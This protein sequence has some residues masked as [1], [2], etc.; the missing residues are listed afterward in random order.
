MI[1]ADN[2]DR[3]PLGTIAERASRALTVPGA[4]TW[5][6]TRLKS[7]ALLAQAAC[8][9]EEHEWFGPTRCQTHY[10][11]VMPAQFWEAEWTHD[12]DRTSDR[13]TRL[14][15]IQR[16]TLS[17]DW[18]GSSFAIISTHGAPAR[19]FSGF[20]RAIG[21]SLHRDDAAA[22]LAHMDL[23]AAGHS[24]AHSS[25]GRATHSR[26]VEWCRNWIENG[27]GRNSTIA[28]KAFSDLPEFENNSRDDD[29]R[30]AWNEAKNR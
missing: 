7:G 24:P 18:H 8:Y 1:G 17:A 30:P 22:L 28:W 13:N 23:I 16:A 27:S 10:D 21:V 19:T 6:M 3:V 25:P 15:Y 29:F 11:Y 12:G 20:R 4:R 5:L 26:V 14:D 9:L 2:K